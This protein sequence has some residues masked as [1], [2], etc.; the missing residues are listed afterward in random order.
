MTSAQSSNVTRAPSSLWRSTPHNQDESHRCSPTTSAR[1]YSQRASRTRS[2]RCD[3]AHTT[4]RCSRCGCPRGSIASGRFARAAEARASRRARRWLRRR[5]Q[6]R[7]LLSDSRRVIQPVARF[8]CSG[9]PI[10]FPGVPQHV[11]TRRPRIAREHW[12]LGRCTACASCVY[13]HFTGEAD[14]TSGCSG[15]ESAGV[16]PG[17]DGN[18]LPTED[19]EIVSP[20]G[21]KLATR[22]PTGF[23]P[24]GITHPRIC[25]ENARQHP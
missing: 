19:F 5:G 12:G 23:R 24:A 6:L 25:R 17:P 2:S 22:V 21:R 8:C 14:G 13:T 18:R 11:D 1:C 16:T 7:V 15:L 3:C 10:S 9:M 4:Y 20:A